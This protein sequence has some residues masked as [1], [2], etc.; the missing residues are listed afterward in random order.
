MFKDAWNKLGMW[1]SFFNYKFYKIEIQKDF[2]W[3]FN[4]QIKMY[5]K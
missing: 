3:K 5:Y 1:I 2:L 4:I